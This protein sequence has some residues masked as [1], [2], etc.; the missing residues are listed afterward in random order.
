MGVQS[1]THDDIIIS[2]ATMLRTQPKKQVLTEVTLGPAWTGK[3]PGRVD[4]MTMAKCYARL[5]VTIYECKVSRADFLGDVREGKYTKYLG[6]CNRL[7]FAAPEGM[8]EISEIPAGAGLICLG[9]NGWAVRKGAKS[10]GNKELPVAMYKAIAINA[11]AEYHRHDRIKR[12]EEVRALAKGHRELRDFGALTFRSHIGTLLKEASA[13]KEDRDYLMGALGRLLQVP[14]EKREPWRLIAMLQDRLQ[15]RTTHVHHRGTEAPA[16]KEASA[17]TPEQVFH[18][19]EDPRPLPG[20][21]PQAVEEA[22]VYVVSEDFPTEVEGEA[23]PPL[24]PG[25]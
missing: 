5:D 4:V 16:A 17:P 14:E 9:P 15:E 18:Q 7:Y 10:Q 2:L 1:V 12:L 3:H 22:E 8:L 11:R 19:R 6:C 21:D 20:R 23:L 24:Q 13:V 25:G